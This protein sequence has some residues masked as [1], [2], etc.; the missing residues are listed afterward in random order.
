MDISIRTFD[1]F[2][3]NIL[4]QNAILS[5]WGEVGV[6]KTSLSL[7]VAFKNA[8]NEHNII[9]I[10]TKPNFPFEK[11]YNFTQQLSNKILNNIKFIKSTDFEDI[12]S[13]VFNLEFIVANEFK[14]QNQIIK[15]I[16]IDSVTDLYRLKLNK[17]KKEKNFILNYKLNQ[18][19]ANLSY[20]NE[21][22]DI[23]ILI[24]NDITYKQQD[25]KTK[26]IQSGGMVMDYWI[27]T[28]IKI[29]RTDKLNCRRLVFK[30]RS[31]NEFY[32][33]TSKLTT[34][35]FKVFKR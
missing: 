7:Q 5:I 22:H 13:L 4:L 10:Y 18:L 24:V 29:T 9:Y 23:N 3:N 11:V 34:T 20:L 15:L 16:V 12:Y 14:R 30:K 19:L 1:E 32:E 25:G 6:G 31:T 27:D 2:F 35:G 17:E 26:E 28:S 33:F 8:L 21:Q